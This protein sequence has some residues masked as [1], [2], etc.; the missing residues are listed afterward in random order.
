MFCTR[1]ATMRKLLLGVAVVTAVSAGTAVSV[2]PAANAGLKGNCHWMNDID[3][4]VMDIL[5][6]AGGAHGVYLQQVGGPVLADSNGGFEY[7]P[8][9]SI[10]PLIA[11][12]A[13]TQ[14]ED[15]AAQ[16]S[17]PVPEIS[18]SGGPDDCPPSTFT[19]TE[20]LGTALRQML[21]V[22][23]NN[24]TDEL[25]R[26]F[27]VSNLNNFAT[28]L[29]LTGT[30]FQTSSSAPGFNVIGCLAY[31]LNPL[32][33]TVDGNTMTLSD[34]A[35]VWTDIADLPA[36]YPAEFY[37]LA[38]GRDMYNSQGY[39]FTGIWPAMM[40]VARQEAP[41]GL[42]A[43][44][45]QSYIDHMTVSVKGGGYGETD[46]TG[47][48]SQA[49]WLVF[50]GN[51][52]IPSCTGHLVSETYYNWGYFINDAVQ[53]GSSG[54]PVANQ[55]FGEADAQLLAAPIAQGLASWASCAPHVTAS[56]RLYSLPL[57]G[58]A[59]VPLTRLLA[60]LSDTDQ[61]DIPADLYG[62]INWGDGSPVSDLAMD[63]GGH[64]TFFL[65]G[66]HQYPQS[67]TYQLT[68]NVTD[69]ASGKTATLT[70]PYTVTG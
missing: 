30:H 39:D 15:G 41:A 26:F 17:E 52:V 42:P 57:S 45:V 59:T 40:T 43:A 47:S 60:L 19:G 6:P 50:A 62:T 51:A 28:S 70:E 8:A 66:W 31:N 37:E 9:S 10:K 58:P 11:L 61:T 36:P 64:G 46:C 34:A 55:V 33:S 5:Y 23:D 7:E 69:I 25:M 65:Q 44:E 53:A 49:S 3:T 20:P 32:P 48:C 54:N 27:G 38:A 21:Q 1:S 13:L 56:L 14:V 22:S 35:K 67:G 18:E 2:A 24:R 4:C 68:I 63:R 16:L 12:Y 29:G